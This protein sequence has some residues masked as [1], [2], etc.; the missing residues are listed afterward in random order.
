MARVVS[1][2]VLVNFKID[3]CKDDKCR[4]CKLPAIPH[5]VLNCGHALCKPCAG[6][7]TVC[8]SCRTPLGRFTPDSHV[9]DRIRNALRYECIDPEH[10][11]RGCA[12]VGNF[13]DAKR[14]AAKGA[15]ILEDFKIECDASYKCRVCKLPAIP[16]IDLSCGHPVC[17]RC[18]KRVDTCP[19]CDKR[20]SQRTPDRCLT[21]QIT[22][23]LRYRCASAAHA[24]HGC[25]FV[26]NFEEAKRHAEDTPELTDFEVDCDE[27]D[28]CPVCLLPAIPHIVL[29]CGHA[30]CK[31]C[32][33]RVHTCPS[34]R[35][36]VRVRTSYHQMSERIRGSL[37]Y[38]CSHPAHKRAGGCTFVGNF[39]EAKRHA[40]A[41]EIVLQCHDAFPQLTY[42]EIEA[43]VKGKEEHDTDGMVTGLIEASQRKQ[44]E[45]ASSS[46]CAEASVAIS[47]ISIAI[48]VVVLMLR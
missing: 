18:A 25:T 43:V 19:A 40:A 7:T 5:V 27:S 31:T 45:S 2:H 34:C 11:R 20:V 15:H 33:E 48:V 36:A 37:R 9:T 30:L 12:F 21:K 10:A 24:R 16:Y 46:P 14:H 29:N 13:E 6:R 41:G 23:S 38:R 42:A 17:Q 32:A 3:C 28:L 22:G 35:T 39:A 4:L 26:G 1:D 47:I 8:P 44:R